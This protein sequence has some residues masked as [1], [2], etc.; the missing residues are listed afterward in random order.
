M[1][2]EFGKE[3]PEGSCFTPV[4]RGEGQETQSACSGQILLFPQ[5]LSFDLFVYSAFSL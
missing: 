1:P 4:W 5:G 3:N 2:P